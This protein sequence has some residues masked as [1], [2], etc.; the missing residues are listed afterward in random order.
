MN[1]GQNCEWLDSYPVI[2]INLTRSGFFCKT[3]HQIRIEICS[4]SG[5]LKTLLFKSGFPSCS[6]ETLSL[7]L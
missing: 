1:S 5:V 6:L 3:W 2:I 4:K 7:T